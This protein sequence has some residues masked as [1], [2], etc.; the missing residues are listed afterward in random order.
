LIV[1][2]G[3]SSRKLQS[4]INIDFDINDL[5]AS[6]D[7]SN[8]IEETQDLHNGSVSHNNWLYVRVQKPF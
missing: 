1:T 4:T 3:I 5:K 6:L 2:N 7:D 8:F